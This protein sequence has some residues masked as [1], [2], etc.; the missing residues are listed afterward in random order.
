MDL[1][2][3]KLTETNTINLTDSLEAPILKLKIKTTEGTTIPTTNDLII[4]VKRTL[5]PESEEKVYIFTLDKPL[6]ANDV[7]CDEFVIEPIVKN[8]RSMMKGYV[9]RNVG[10]DGLLENPL[11][12]NVDVEDII[13]YEGENHIS[14]NYTNCIIEIMYP[15]DCELIKTLL[16]LNS[17]DKDFD[18]SSFEDLYFKDCFT[19][20]DDGKINATFNKATVKCFNSENQTFSMDCEGNLV[21]NSIT[22]REDLG[23]DP[24]PEAP[25]FDKIYP[26]GA[27]YLSVSNV[28]PSTL[29]GG[30]WEQISDVFLLGAGTTYGAGTTG[31]SATNSHTHSFSHTHSVP[32]VSHSHNLG[33][34]GYAKLNLALSGT[35]L[36]AK[37]NENT[38]F[39][40]NYYMKTS[41]K[42]TAV[43]NDT[44]SGVI[45]L[46]GR[47]ENTTPGNATTNSQ[48]TATT[49]GAS[50]INNMPPYL[51]VYM[52]KRT[53]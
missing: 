4:N 44:T 16:S 7:T 49:G 46:G 48:S 29:F 11:I 30:T 43:S 37:M 39:A 14:T 6:Q 9:I 2:N 47:T 1:E 38:S 51:A 40:E 3:L 32:G 52:W 23:K 36:Y 8:N 31:G 10:D 50:N 41:G 22:T 42:R 21:V 53:A 13:L 17:L 33:D 19:K 26:V 18:D 45:L 5:E 35:Y 12:E 24:V 20:L 27:I 15:K 25:N 28:N 34:N